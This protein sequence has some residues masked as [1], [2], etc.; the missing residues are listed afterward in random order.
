MNELTKQ[1]LKEINKK[2]DN[3]YKV[4]GFVNG[5]YKNCV[6][7]CIIKCNE[8]GLSSGWE[9]PSFPRY[10]DLFHSLICSKCAGKYIHTKEEILKILKIKFKDKFIINGY[11]EEFKGKETKIDIIC[12]KHGAGKDW[13]TPWKPRASQILSERTSCPK[14]KKS[15]RLK[16]KEAITL[17]KQKLSST[18]TF[19]NFIGDFK[20]IETTKCILKCKNHGLISN[21]N[22]PYY[23][24]V[25]TILTKEDKFNCSK[26]ENKYIKSEFEVLE[27][28]NKITKS[29]LKILGFLEEYKN[30]RSKCK[31]K[32]EIHGNGWEWENPWTPNT[33]KL[34]K[35]YG[36][37]KCSKRYVKTQKEVEKEIKQKI[38]GKYLFKGF[39][40]NKYKGI[41]TK[42][43]LVCPQ[44]GEGW[45]LEKPWTPT[46]QR[47]FEG[48]E[49][50]KCQREL[51]SFTNSIKDIDKFNEERTLYFIQ[52]KDLNTN[53]I[54]YK[55][56]LTKNDI[57][58]RFSNFKLNK[59]NIKKIKQKEIK[60][61]NIAAI[62]SEKFI[63]NKFEKNKKP[64][65]HRLKETGGGGECFNK[66]ITNGTSLKNF[67][68][69][70]FLN[71]K[72]T[73]L[74]FNLSKEEYKKAE[75]EILKIIKEENFTF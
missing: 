16:E 9:N 11:I 69:E 25:R 64:M 50:S 72:T 53:K 66:D 56:G 75:K 62:L 54:F 14:C 2:I 65:F 31:I 39:L 74:T 43:L 18:L 6:T 29:H 60:L 7:P 67:V 52:F 5:E 55:I 1:K 22:N 71:Y 68:N 61:K 35:G 15:Y 59:D 42:C 21:W 41:Y 45:E 37:P 24:T 26:C 10:R 38:K 47:I 17:I 51:S 13:N 73:L 30:S 48:R 36:C 23:P 70:A 28:L 33:L 49:C 27:E 19:V 63:L 20:S 46:V 34:K 32:C 40:N 57:N 4:I 44:H 12:K 8:H 58:V 3:K